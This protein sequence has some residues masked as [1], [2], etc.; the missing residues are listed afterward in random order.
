[1][2]LSDFDAAILTGLYL[3]L[4]ANKQCQRMYITKQKKALVCKY[5][6]RKL[7]YDESPKSG[8]GDTC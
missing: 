6:N 1:M 7:K 5:R 3:A 2:M 4:P 8:E